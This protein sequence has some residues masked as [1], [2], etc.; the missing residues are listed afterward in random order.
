MTSDVTGRARSATGG[1]RG[2]VR[3]ASGTCGRSR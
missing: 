1:R 3:G 2:G